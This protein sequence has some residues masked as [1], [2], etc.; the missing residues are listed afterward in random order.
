LPPKHVVHGVRSTDGA[1]AA[2]VPTLATERVVTGAAGATSVVLVF[3]EALQSGVAYANPDDATV[4]SDG[5]AYR[6]DGE[7]REATALGLERLPSLDAMYF[8]WYGFYPDGDV[9]TG[10]EDASRERATGARG[11]RSSVERR[12]S[13]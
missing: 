12:P 8:A 10:T 5:D 1:F 7:R 2:S 11:T 4:E 9:R 6:V 13:G 3:D